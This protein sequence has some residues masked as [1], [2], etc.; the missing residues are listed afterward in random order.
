MDQT[1]LYMI[2]IFVIAN[3]HWRCYVAHLLVRNHTNTLQLLCCGVHFFWAESKI[4]KIQINTTA[5]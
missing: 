3:L 1:M 5:K 2:L 4:H